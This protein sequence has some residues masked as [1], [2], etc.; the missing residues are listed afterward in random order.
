LTQRQ[1]LQ[2]KVP[3]RPQGA[4]QRTKA[5][6]KESKPDQELLQNRSEG[7]PPMLLIFRS[8]GVFANNSKVIDEKRVRLKEAVLQ[9]GTRFEYLYDFGDSWRHDL[10]LEAIVL[11][12]PEGTYPCCLAG[13]RCAPPENVGGIVLLSRL[14][15]GDC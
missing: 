12:D 15:G 7:A 10:Q 14:P 11:P 1:I 3:T 4:T 6:N 13:E 5:Q 8:A 9:V 2:P